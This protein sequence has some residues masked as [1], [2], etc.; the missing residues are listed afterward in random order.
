MTINQIS[1]QPKI[2]CAALLL[3]AIAPVA[4]AAKP[5]VTD[6]LEEAETIFFSDEGAEGAY[7]YLGDLGALSDD[8]EILFERARYAGLAGLVDEAEGIYRT[9]I[10]R[11]PDDGRNYN[12][13]GRLLAEEEYVRLPEALD[14]IDKALELN[15]AEPRFYASYG[16]GLQQL[17][18][19]STAEE[20]YRNALDLLEGKYEREIFQEY[21]SLLLLRGQT[22]R[23]G[24]IMAVMAENDFESVIFPWLLWMVYTEEVPEGVM[25]VLAGME[26]E[27]IEDNFLTLMHAYAFHLNGDAEMA[28]QKLGRV[29]TDENSSLEELAVYAAILREIGVSA[30]AEKFSRFLI[31]QDPDNPWYY[32]ALGYQLAVEGRKL[33]EAIDILEQGLELAPERPELLATYGWALYGQGRLAAARALMERA[34]ESEQDPGQL[35]YV[36][37]LARHGE[38]LWEMGE[39]DAAVATWQEGWRR[40][41]GHRKL[42]EILERYGQSYDEV[43]EQ[44]DSYIDR[45]LGRAE[46]LEDEYDA[47]AAY[48]YLSSIDLFLDSELL[49]LVQADYAKEA[50]LYEA[51]ENLYRSL[52]E[53]DPENA[54]YYNYL[55]YMLVEH[56]DR[57]VEAGLVLEKALELAPEDPLI[58]DSL[59]W[60]LY[61]SGRPEEALELIGQALELMD[62]MEIEDE[63][64]RIE[65]MAHYGEILWELGYTEKAVDVWYEAWRLD[66][67]DEN[68]ALFTT[69]SRY[70]QEYRSYAK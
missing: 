8:E 5:E 54:D 17:G 22:D 41:S 67:Y 36:E 3:W 46:Y 12:A 21:V 34:L 43:E 69:L 56:T 68:E 59:G 16:Y 7:E 53:R 25:E 35:A 62:V 45:V 65:T 13:L 27:G 1:L 64:A 28:K 48:L 15:P 47:R 60:A 58:M 42:L 18:Y 29:D 23:A 10:R 55:G 70:S 52:I 6:A 32:H 40:D 26:E 33:D 31:N 19:L 30:E 24:R 9:L 50:G 20:Y 44:E 38:I 57:L 61:H 39:R 11:Q 2:A 66:Y 14:L 37:G 4:L 51:A 49:M 63:Q